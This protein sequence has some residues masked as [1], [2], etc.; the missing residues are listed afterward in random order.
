MATLERPSPWRRGGGTRWRIAML[1]PLLSLVVGARAMAQTPDPRQARLETEVRHELMMLPY[2]NVFDNLAFQIGPK[3]Q[4][5]LLGQVVRPTLKTDAERVVK[6]I[7]G[8]EQVTNEIETLPVSPN[9]DRIRIAT[10]RAIYRHDA[11]ER[12]AIQAVPPIHIVVKNGHVTLEGAVAIDADR[13]IA[14]LQARMVS[15][16]FSVTNNLRVAP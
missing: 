1:F 13:T 7:Q 9:D 6:R 16:V 8:V 10:Y 3:G 5:T 2:Y 15:G 14:N 12:Y 4:V 11:L